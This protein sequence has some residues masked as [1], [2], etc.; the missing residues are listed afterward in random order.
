MTLE[1]VQEETGLDKLAVDRA[2]FLIEE[3]R[4]VIPA[5]NELD[6]LAKRQKTEA[7]QKVADFALSFKMGKIDMDALESFFKKPYPRLE[8]ARDPKGRLISNTWRLTI[9][10]FIPMNVGWL[11]SQDDSYNYFRVNRYMD[12]FGELPQFIKDEIGWKDAPDLKI[13][14]EELVG[15][16]KQVFETAKKYP[17]L[18]KE[19]DGKVLVNKDRYY[20][21][22]V[23]LLKEGAKPFPET[24]VD[25]A[26]LVERKCDYELRPY[27]KE[28][29]DQFCRFSRQGV[30]IPPGTGKTVVGCWALTHLRPPHLVVVPT[31]MLKEQWQ[32]RIED[33]TD[34]KLGEEV[35]VETYITAIKRFA[36]KQFTL[37][38]I[39]EVHHI[40]A[41]YYIRLFG[42]HSRYSIGLSATPYREDEGGEELVFALTGNPV[43]LS[44]Q[45]FR[46]L[47]LI[48]SPPCHVWIEPKQEAKVDRIAYLLRDPKKTI[49]FC[50]FIA[51]GETLAKKFD[52]PFV[53][54][55]TKERLATI[56]EAP[57]CIVS[58][59]G[60][61]GVSLPD[62][63]RVIEYSW[64]YGSRRQ[65][66]QRFGRLL[67]SQ[68]AYPDQHVLMTLEEY[69]HDKKR[70]FSIMDKGFKLVLHREGVSDKAIERTER[71]PRQ[72]RQPRLTT[73][74]TI[75]LPAVP[76]GLTERL[77]G[78]T[79]TLE[80]LESVEK[81]VARTIL[82]NPQRPYSATE[83]ALAT[84][85]SSSTIANLAH[86]GK[87]KEM[88]LIKEAG[89]GK[90]QSAL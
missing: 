69:A 4:R 66:L 60:D 51:P 65:E 63:Q 3:L 87:L 68:M 30:F 23:A 73:P 36:D 74:S 38:V 20:E 49:I 19:K 29:W 11:E 88:G 9:P 37:K 70:F 24:P 54:G 61:E 89:H 34:L 17:G 75:A 5:I 32:E 41:Q 90:Y 83:L 43:G 16:R 22:L 76:T 12:W 78:I 52:C 82:G 72:V 55:A 81:A 15:D 7:Q 14:G 27:Q 71:Q 18:L 46:D 84:G 39:D 35:F 33:H 47:K 53:H 45:S 56:K 48:S 31:V 57:V 58:R 59:V 8:P 1:Q 26:D 62:L 25:H 13:E 77:P 80:R 28:I 64:N 85:L 21:L 6:T 2:Q 42:I 44:W 86:F 40:G 50:D 10:R 67:H 79:K